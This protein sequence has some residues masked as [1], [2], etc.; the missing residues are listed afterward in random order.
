MVKELTY[1][2]ASR[3]EPG[4]GASLEKYVKGIRSYK[5]NSSTFGTSVHNSFLSAPGT[6]LGLLCSFLY[7]QHPGGPWYSASNQ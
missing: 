2:R 7:P 5:R 1:A 3:N 4:I 6:E